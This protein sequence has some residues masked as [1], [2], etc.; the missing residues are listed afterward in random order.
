MCD[1]IPQTSARV[2]AAE[3]ARRG[4]AAWRHPHPVDDGDRCV[5]PVLLESDLPGIQ[6][7]VQVH[8]VVLETMHHRCG[9][10]GE[11]RT[12]VVRKC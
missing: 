2:G 7:V 10:C 11:R 4:Q 1:G 8:P 6:V 9:L 3:Q 12:A 5:L